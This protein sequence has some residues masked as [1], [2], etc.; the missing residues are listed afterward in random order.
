MAQGAGSGKYD[1]IGK[2]QQQR[3]RAGWCQRWSADV[4]ETK[5]DDRTTSVAEALLGGIEDPAGVEQVSAGLAR[6]I[7]AV[8]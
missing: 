7:D 1:G 5:P 6:L 3:S 8:T 4:G 2:A